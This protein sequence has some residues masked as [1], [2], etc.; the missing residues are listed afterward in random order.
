MSAVQS[1]F[2]TCCLICM[3]RDL[4]WHW[5]L[6]FV[7]LYLVVI[8]FKSNQP[9]SFAESSAY[10]HAVDSQRLAS[11]MITSN[12]TRN[13][14][15]SYDFRFGPDDV[16]SENYPWSEIASVYN[17]KEILEFGFHWSHMVD[18]EV[19]FRHTCRLSHGLSKNINC[20]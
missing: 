5:Q 4:V 6:M 16:A 18:S 12:T 3:D 19:F 1:E 14:P 11:K 8:K 15:L 10:D 17:G 20:N 2:P 7:L 13:Y 9:L